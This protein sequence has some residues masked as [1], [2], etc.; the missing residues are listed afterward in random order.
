VQE[1]KGARE[2]ECVGVLLVAK[3]MCE[4]AKEW[5][6]DDAI[7][8]AALVQSSLEPIKKNKN[9]SLVVFFRNNI[10]LILM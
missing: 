10:N 8:Q 7:N 1:G 3:K 6:E 5:S 4:E 2:C 9:H